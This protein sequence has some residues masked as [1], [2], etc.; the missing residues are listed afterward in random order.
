MYFLRWLGI[1]W[2]PVLRSASL[3]QSMGPNQCHDLNYRPPTACH[4]MWCMYFWVIESHSNILLLPKFC[5]WELCNTFWS[6]HQ[7]FGEGLEMSVPCFEPVVPRFVTMFPITAHKLY[8]WFWAQISMY[9]NIFGLPVSKP[10]YSSSDEEERSVWASLCTFFAEIQRREILDLSPPRLQSGP[11]STLQIQVA[12]D[13]TISRCS[14]SI[15][16]PNR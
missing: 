14:T 15:T 1:G 7:L 16:Q 9:S 10:A 8:W 3:L 2:S 11:C 5:D 6:L 13:F 4:M 12:D